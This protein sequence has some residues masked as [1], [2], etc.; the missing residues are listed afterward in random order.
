MTAAVTVK[1]NVARSLTASARDIF[2]STLKQLRASLSDDWLP[3][4]LSTHAS[5][6]V[7]AWAGAP[8]RPMAASASTVLATVARAMRTFF[9]ILL[10]SCDGWL[11]AICRGCGNGDCL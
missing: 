1:V 9:V 2:A 4:G 11:A 5:A 10:T 3:D 6:G 7:R 8:D